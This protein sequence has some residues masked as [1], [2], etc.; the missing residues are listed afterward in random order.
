MC[1]DGGMNEQVGDRDP[2][3]QF[4]N[5]AERHAKLSDMD[6][7]IGRQWSQSMP[8]PAWSFGDS[9]ELAD[10]LLALVLEGHKTAT[11]SLRS[12]FGDDG[13]PLPS[14]G[15]LSIVLDGQGI[16]AALIKTVEVQI[17]PFSE[18]TENQAA[19]EGEGDRSVETWRA[20]HKRFWKRQGEKTTDQT[21]IVWERFKVVYRR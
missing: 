16:P 1:D 4:W 3:Q 13:E 17:V 2:I 11:S 5:L 14:K 19:A 8:P 20:D 21:L 9:P 10:E 6:V 12:E 18:V 7:I 15:D